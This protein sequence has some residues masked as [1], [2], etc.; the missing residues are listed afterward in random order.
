MTNRAIGYSW[1]KTHTIFNIYLWTKR[2]LFCFFHWSIQICLLEKVSNIFWLE[3]Y[4]NY[5]SCFAFIWRQT[6]HFLF[7]TCLR[8]FSVMEEFLYRPSFKNS[9]LIVNDDQHKNSCMKVSRK[10]CYSF[11]FHSQIFPVLWKLFYKVSPFYISEKKFLS[12]QTAKNVNG[13]WNTW[14]T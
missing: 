13:L 12:T 2:Y 7:Y 6:L 10:V 5:F 1:P 3:N 8:N 11:L 9:N 14:D 4:N